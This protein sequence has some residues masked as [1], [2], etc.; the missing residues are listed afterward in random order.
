MVAGL[1]TYPAEWTLAGERDL[2]MRLDEFDREW[3]DTFAQWM[4]GP[5]SF[6]T[7]AE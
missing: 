2:A 5:G 1:G 3:L 6:V 7:A 4:R